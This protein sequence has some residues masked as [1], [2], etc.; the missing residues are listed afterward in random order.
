[1]CKFHGIKASSL[2]YISAVHFIEVFTHEINM[3]GAVVRNDA[4]T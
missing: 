2:V 1:M 3:L 4:M